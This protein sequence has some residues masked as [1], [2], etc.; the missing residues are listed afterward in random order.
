[1]V[2]KLADVFL[3]HLRYDFSPITD[4]VSLMAGA[5][6]LHLW[7][8]IVFVCHPVIINDFLQFLQLLDLFFLALFGDKH[9]IS[10][11]HNIVL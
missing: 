4:V 7:P 2:L 11:F 8:Q 5:L 6:D 10:V 9:A 3:D 1:M